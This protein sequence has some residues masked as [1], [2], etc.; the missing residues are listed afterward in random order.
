[1][2]VARLRDR[3]PSAEVVGSYSLKEHDLRFHKSSKDG[4]GKCDAYFTG[5]ET[6]RVYGVLF[7]ISVSEKRTLDRAEGLGYGYKEQEV[8]VYS[9]NGQICKALTYLATNIDEKLAPYT[10]YKQHV[11][12]GAKEA[13]LPQWYIEKIERVSAIDDEDKDRDS[14][15]RAIHS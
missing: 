7:K 12:V 6:D 11:L 8:S 5:A 10:W 14:E 9:E 3:V 1:M 4:S 15:Q 13:F 2:S